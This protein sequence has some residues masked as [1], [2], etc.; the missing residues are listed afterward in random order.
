MDNFGTINGIPKRYWGD[1]EPSDKKVIWYKNNTPYAY[2]DGEW[3]PLTGGSSA[4]GLGA[5]KDFIDKTTPD[6][7]TIPDNAIVG[8]KMKTTLY[9]IDNDGIYGDTCGYDDLFAGR[10][11][12][13]NAAFNED[14]GLF[15]PISCITNSGGKFQQSIT[16]FDYNKSFSDSTKKL[17]GLSRIILMKRDNTWSWFWDDVYVEEFEKLKD[18][19]LETIGADIIYYKDLK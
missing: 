6:W 14:T 19:Y 12:Y 1:K 16:M 7:Y 13:I 4:T 10:P 3:K 8:I 11:F 17:S 18:D 15:E 9:T 2:Q 5:L